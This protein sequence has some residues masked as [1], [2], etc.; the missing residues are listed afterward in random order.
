MIKRWLTQTL[1][2]MEW[3]PAYT[4]HALRADVIAGVVVLFITVPQV[5]AYAFLAGLP[6]ETGLYAAIMA[7][8]CY[9]AFGSCRTLAVGPAAIMSMMTLEAMTT[10]EVPGTLAYA[11]LASKLTLITGGILLLLRIINFGAVI[12][13]LSHAVVTGFITAAAI[14]IIVNQL[15]PIFGLDSPAASGLLPV[16]EYTLL[17]LG[18]TN[19]VALAIAV[20]AMVLLWLARNYLEGLLYRLGLN[21]LWA[22]SLVKSAPMYAVVISILLVWSM[23][24][25][26]TRQLAV[27]GLIQEQLPSIAMLSVSMADVQQ[28]APSALLMAMVIFM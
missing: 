20:S 13:F 10:F 11:V 3:L 5:I 17:G 15:P 18:A 26:E 4:L 19:Q 21:E 16:L 23:G 22:S 9:A 7:L 25:A 6:A 1:P 27:V 12:S 24:L 8:L 28:L 14:L 2:V